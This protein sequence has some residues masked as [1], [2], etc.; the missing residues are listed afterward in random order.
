MDSSSPLPRTNS[1]CIHFSLLP[2]PFLSFF[3]AMMG[4]MESVVV[5]S[6]GCTAG[7]GAPRNLML[8]CGPRNTTL[9][10]QYQGSNSDLV[11]GF[12][13]PS[14]EGNEERCD[15]FGQSFLL[16]Q[17]EMPRPT[18]GYLIFNSQLNLIAL[19]SSISVL[20][21]SLG[22]KTC[23]FSGL[24]LSSSQAQGQSKPRA[25]SSPTHTLQ[26]VTCFH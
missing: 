20:L 18:C 14:R 7:W 10:G 23:L 19:F 9:P 13:Y 12:P 24:T 5:L 2:A 3:V 8:N 25:C 11:P 6:R 21:G 15:W 4:A 22:T 17:E 26:C 1:I 16:T